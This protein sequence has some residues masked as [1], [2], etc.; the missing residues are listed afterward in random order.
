MVIRN[1]SRQRSVL[2]T[3]ISLTLTL[4]AGAAA[5]ASATSAGSSAP[6]LTEVTVTGLPDPSGLPTSLGANSAGYSEAQLEQDVNVIDTS[7]IVKYSPD[8][9]TRKRYIGDRN[10]IIETR[11][12]SVTTSA[13][14][15]VYVDGILI[16]N[17][18][19]NGYAYP[20]RW[21]M[22]MPEELNRVDFFFGPFAAA[23]GGSSVGTTVLMTTTMPDHF[24]VSAKAQA[25]SEDFGYLGHS[26]T[27]TGESYSAS[28]G[29]RTGFGLSWL[30]G[31]DRLESHGHPMT[32]ATL[33]A[34]T[35]CTGSCP[36]STPVVS[37]T[38][39][40]VDPYGV[41]Q[42]AIGGQSLDT[43]VQDTFKLKLEQAL[44]SVKV[45]YT[46]GGWS[47][48]TFNAAQSWLTDANGTPVN[49][50]SS[51][52]V[53]INGQ[54]YS[55]GT[56]FAQ[57]A[58]DQQHTMQA[59]SIIGGEH[60]AVQWELVGSVYTINH[61]LQTS[62]IPQGTKVGTTTYYGQ[63]TRNPYGDGWT[64]VDGRGLWKIGDGTHTLAFGAHH[65]K[66]SLDTRADYTAEAND[67]TW[68]SNTTGVTQKQG[69]TGNTSTDAAYLQD[70]W[71]MG[72]RWRAIAGLRVEKWTAENGSNAA[73]VKGA[74]S[75]VQ[76]AD[77]SISANSPKFSIE[78]DVSADWTLRAALGKAYR[79]PTVTELYQSIAGPNT[80][81]TN[82]PDLRP[83]QALTTELTA[84]R[85]LESGLIRAS[86]FQ[87]HL[88]DAL[89]SQTTLIP[90]VGNTTAVSNIDLVQTR[91]AEMAV[92]V[93][94]AGMKGLDVTG[95]LTYAMGH[96]LKDTFNPSYEGKV[97]PGVPRW[98]ATLV[99]TWHAT[100]KQTLTVAARYSGQQYNT[101][102]N[103]DTNYDTYTS[104]SPYTVVDLRWLSDLG[105]GWKASIGVDNLLDRTYFAY[106]PMP[107]R[108]LHVEVKY[109]H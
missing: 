77:K 89:Y 51:G 70:A 38:A 10:A 102:G 48:K 45:R 35:T 76:Y 36:A 7:D 28:V 8:T 33:G 78:T 4:A 106:H 65:D 68:Q 13:H 59:L 39:T 49:Y 95:N 29:D 55:L 25:F 57:N 41:T 14:S 53:A 12:G 82:N 64:V 62:S 75:S 84:S 60:S 100:E 6:L 3:L 88:Q 24:T 91:G 20:A 103:T 47:N 107:Q 80:L 85:Q 40:F 105:H 101:L 79:F 83:E 71:R 61:D 50:S 96:T 87:E 97:Y 15:L 73:L 32:Y 43:T 42:T 90:G 56:S 18:L 54:Y 92:Q 30:L 104:N 109:H 31:A 63:V 17:L 81:I 16:S 52:K 22:V 19:G 72:S 5:S 26:G 93:V 1:E 67:G 69:S 44:G 99:S 58:W 27:Y 37:G 11:T 108:T 94:D 74:L 46:L 34:P 2:Q 21:N 66:Y 98:R 23:Y 86:V 9:M